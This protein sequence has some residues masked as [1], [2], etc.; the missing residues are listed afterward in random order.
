MCKT[1]LNDFPELQNFLRKYCNTFKKL[2]NIRAHQIAGE[3]KILPG[4]FIYIPDI[5]NEKGK[6]IDYREKREK[7]INYGVFINKIN[8]HPHSPYDELEDIFV[9]LE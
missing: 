6:Y 2:R 7:M 3:V 9:S 1:E 4:G 5:G 8:L